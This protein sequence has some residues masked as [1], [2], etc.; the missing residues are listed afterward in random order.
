ML[1]TIFKAIIKGCKKIWA[2]LLLVKKIDPKKVLPLSYK[3]TGE[4][5]DYILGILI[6]VAIALVG[7][8]VIGVGAAFLG[9]AWAVILGI[10][11]GLIEA[12]VVAGIL[13]ESLVQFNVIKN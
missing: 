4:L 13:I 2:L 12:Y 3:F 6:Y 5:I 8:I 7:G 10:L 11:G 9:G 1:K